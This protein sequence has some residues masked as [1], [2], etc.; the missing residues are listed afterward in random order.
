[1]SEQPRAARVPPHDLAAEE[2]VLGSILL[3][4]G[5]AMNEIAL[6][7]RSNDFYKPQHGVV[8]EA[9]SELYTRGEPID[10][11][12]VGQAL[13]QMGQIANV[14]GRTKLVQLEQAVP[15]TLTGP[16]YARIV[17][18]LATKRAGLRIAQDLVAEGFDPQ[19]E[20]DDFVSRAQSR[21]FSLALSE[22][23]QGFERVGDLQLNG[24]ME[25]YHAANENGGITGLPTG[26]RDVD[27]LLKGLRRSEL[28]IVAG[29]TSMG[30]TSLVLNM[31]IN[32]LKV[33][34]HAG[35]AIFSLEMSKENL[36]ERLVAQV[37]GVDS[38]KLREGSLAPAEFEQVNRAVDKLYGLPIY[39]DADPM[40]DSM[41]MLAK[42]RQLHQRELTRGGVGLG[43]CVIDYIQ[44]MTASGNARD[45]NRTQEVGHIAK[46]CRSVARELDIP[47]IGVSQLSRANDKRED[48]RPIL[49]DLR[50]SG[51]L[52]QIADVVLFV[53]RPEVY[54]MGE[55]PGIAEI[56]IRKNR[57]GPTGDVDLLFEKRLTQFRDLAQ[58]WR[59]NTA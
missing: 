5:K 9:V 3:S 40:L 36:T 49:S 51:E 4:Q 44:L 39:I 29:K 16:Y 28:V 31:A 48:K 46:A 8:Y 42:V 35:V 57:N 21:F 27:H 41:A 58:A 37:A 54:T 59:Q 55:K 34:P 33:N 25:R 47:V 2:S 53:H 19:V 43:L 17:K 14:G 26:F 7:L 11:V 18:S 32:S 52:E 38:S 15:D 56:L 50:D 30:K 24:V 6:M 22:T 10:V 1:M 45:S 20:P 23:K 12:T 13:E